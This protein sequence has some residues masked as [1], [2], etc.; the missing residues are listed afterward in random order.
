MAII[1]TTTS[2][3]TP[4]SADTSGD[5]YL[6]GPNAIV[7][8]ALDAV[9]GSFAI[10]DRT[11]IVQGSLI[12]N[13]DDGI[14]LGVGGNGGSNRVQVA[15]TG[16]IY[17]AGTGIEVEGGNTSILIEGS[18][19]GETAGIQSGDNTNSIV[20]HGTIGGLGAGVWMLGSSSTM[21]NYGRVSGTG[22]GVKMT[23]GSGHRLFNHGDIVS[24][25]GGADDIAVEIGA[26]TGQTS[27]MFNSGS[28]S[29]STAYRGF[30]GDDTIVNAGTVT[31]TVLMQ[32]GADRLDNTGS[33][34]GTVD[35]GDGAD[36]VVNIGR[37]VGDLTLGSGDD[38]YDGSRGGVVTG[39]IF[40]GDGADVILGGAG[41]ETV[42]Y[43]GSATGVTV[44]LV[45]GIGTGGDAAGDRLTAVEYLVGSDHQDT[46][47]GDG[48]ANNFR[49]GDSRDVLLGGGQGDV[50]RGEGGDDLIGGGEGWD[51]IEG[52][53]GDDGLDA[54]AGN[55]W[56]FGG[57]GND[58]LLG[59]D[60]D[61]TLAG[62][63]GSDTYAGGSGSDLFRLDVLGGVDTVLDFQV[64]IDRLRV[65]GTTQSA[66]VIV[67]NAVQTDGGSTILVLENDT[68]VAL[69]NVTGIT[70]DWFA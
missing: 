38:L 28:I 11:I 20:N 16:Y 37:I 34:F 64:G 65:D 60:G 3:S 43:A 42:S 49:G 24:T 10:T 4:I 50:L 36:T 40:A 47:T 69:L 8:T 58:M 52:G 45:S 35:V 41:V 32:G 55:D 15:S 33:V 26:S 7:T 2:T 46:F 59:D 27:S 57:N 61:D 18:V 19:F 66:A 68:Q 22:E 54:G 1:T 39:I 53:D 9:A 21:V 30:L 62:E 31:G 44:D 67:A 6:I 29:G 5:T 13:G 14:D 48:A 17:A 23:A 70:V 25:G 51:W 63:V 12:S 56:V